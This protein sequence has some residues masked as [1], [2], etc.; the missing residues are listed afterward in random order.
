MKLKLLAA[1][2][3]VAFATP[4]SAA[5]YT[6]SNVFTTSGAGD[7]L[8]QNEDGSLLSGGVVAMGYFNADYTISTTDMAANIGAFTTVASAL[9]GSASASLEGSFAGYVE[10]AGVN[11]GQ[12][13]VGNSLLGRALFVFV[14]N[15]ATLGAS[16]QFAIKQIGVIADDVP[17]NQ[18]YLANPFA[19]APPVLGNV[20]TFTGNAAGPN[21]AG[22][23]IYTTLQLVT[24]VPEPSAALLGAV[25]ALGLLRRRRN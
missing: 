2:A 4:A 14:G 18:E 16:A 9:S 10:A 6:V 7:A 22:S 15:A 13:T 5:L 20:G 17:F 12:I 3:L 11:G 1:A 8:F 21:G 23:S 25:G 24:P 19:G